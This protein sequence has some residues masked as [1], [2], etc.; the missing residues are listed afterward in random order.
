[1]TK[2][3]QGLLHLKDPPRRT[4]L[5]FGIGVFIAFSPFLGLHT[6]M[7][8]AIAFA[9]RLNRIAVLAGAWINALALIPCYLFGTLLGAQLLGVSR[10]NVS[11]LD[12]EKADGF[13][14]LAMS[15]LVVGEWRESVKALG[16]VL[17]V[18]GSFRWPFVIGNMLLA[19]AVGT[20]AYFF[21]RSFL[22]ERA[23]RL[24]V[25]TEGPDASMPPPAKPP[26]V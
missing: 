20:L 18:L 19:V 5:A 4:A 22:E 13:V 9:F 8:I 2:G 3:L 23:H 25:A 17:R 12:L 1:M 16:S 15:S 26:E 14:R 11:A 6:L 7:A 10:R 21:C 24:K